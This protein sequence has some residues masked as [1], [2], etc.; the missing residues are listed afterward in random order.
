[1]CLKLI[2]AQ[3]SPLLISVESQDLIDDLIAY[4]QRALTTG[5][6][7]ILPKFMMRTPGMKRRSKSIEELLSGFIVSIHP[8]NEPVVLAI[9]QMTCLV[10][11]KATR[12]S[13]RR[14]TCVFI[15]RRR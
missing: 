6:L 15:L 12:S 1:M 13:S 4:K 8:P 5:V 9:S 14:R 3:I 10:C 7:K 2:N 11:M